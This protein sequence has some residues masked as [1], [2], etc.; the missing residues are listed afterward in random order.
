MPAPT[1]QTPPSDPGPLWLAFFTPIHQ[2][3]SLADRKSSFL[4]SAGGLITTVLIFFSQPIWRLMHH[5]NR[6]AAIAFIVLLGTLIALLALSAWGAWRAFILPMPRMPKSLALYGDIARLE[7]PA[8]AEEVRNT[9]PTEATRAIV[10]Y[11]Y[12]LAVQAAGKFKLVN[13]SFACFRVALVLWMFLILVVSVV[14]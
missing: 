10:H 1:H 7:R 4:L 6:P 2:Y 3:P 5:Q 13:R 8:Y 14:G 12:S 9:D 11:N